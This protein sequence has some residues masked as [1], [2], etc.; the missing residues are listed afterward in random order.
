MVVYNPLAIPCLR[1]YQLTD[2]FMELYAA[3]DHT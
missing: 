3:S 2:V 1:A